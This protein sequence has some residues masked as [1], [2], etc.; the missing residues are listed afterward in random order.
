MRFECASACTTAR[1][2]A[3]DAIHEPM[4]QPVR[5]HKMPRAS[6]AWHVLCPKQRDS[7]DP[8]TSWN[9]NLHSSTGCAQ[10]SPHGSPAKA[11]KLRFPNGASCQ[12]TPPA[13]H[14]RA[15]ACRPFC[16]SRSGRASAAGWRRRRR[17]SP[18]THMVP[19]MM[20]NL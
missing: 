8:K 16:R 14:T 3:H 18:A 1:C 5:Q 2:H 13:H 12:R 4:Q 9:A 15:A 6:A 11:V 7:R 17:R 20:H 10:R 19:I